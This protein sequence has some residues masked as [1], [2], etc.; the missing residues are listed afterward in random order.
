M[1]KEKSFLKIY[2]FYSVSV[3]EAKAIVCQYWGIFPRGNSVSHIYIYIY[4]INYVLCDKI[5]PSKRNATTNK[6]HIYYVYKF[7]ISRLGG[8]MLPVNIK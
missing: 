3:A 5:K 2:V 1:L 8:V 7:W 4:K 6:L